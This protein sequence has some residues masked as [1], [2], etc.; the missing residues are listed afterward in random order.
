MILHVTARSEEENGDVDG[1]ERRMVAGAIAIGNAGDVQAVLLSHL[2]DHCLEAAAGPRA[3]NTHGLVAHASHHVEIH[4]RYNP[5]FGLGEVGA[6]AIVV[7]HPFQE[8]L[9]TDEPLLLGAK[10]G[11]DDAAR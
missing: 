10:E 8:L 6:A 4:H 2:L 7:L 1:N 5:V 9:G 11:E 3:R